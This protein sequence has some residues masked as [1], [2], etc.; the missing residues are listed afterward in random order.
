MRH[1]HATR[2]EHNNWQQNHQTLHN[3]KSHMTTQW[4]DSTMTWQMTLQ[5][6]DKSTDL[7][8][9]STPVS[10]SRLFTPFQ[11]FFS[12]NTCIGVSGSRGSGGFLTGYW[13]T[14]P[15]PPPPSPPPPWPPPLFTS[16]IMGSCW[17]CGYTWGE[18]S[19]RSS[20]EL[21]SVCLR[22]VSQWLTHATTVLMVVHWRHDWSHNHKYWS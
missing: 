5:W 18:R 21:L 12:L 19:L 13:F 7:I 10:S 15:S 11:F 9:I 4:H 20:S 16:A 8:N 3:R 6:H 22:G 17:R 2:A 14:A 1:Q